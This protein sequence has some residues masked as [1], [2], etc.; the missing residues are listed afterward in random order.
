MLNAK[1]VL[2]IV[3]L[4]SGLLTILTGTAVSQIALADKDKDECKDN[5]DNNCNEETQKIHQENNCKVV[6]ENKNDEKSDKNSN[7]GT[8]AGDITCVNFA[9]NPQDGEAAV[10]LEFPIDP[11]SLIP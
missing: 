2:M 6:N 11:F 1:N 10:N 7:D 9:Q 5:G 3:V 8:S 4:A